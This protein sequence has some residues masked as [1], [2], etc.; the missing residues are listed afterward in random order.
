MTGDRAGELLAEL[1]EGDQP[2]S[3]AAVDALL[4][5]ARYRRELVILSNVLSETEWN[6]LDARC[7]ALT[8]DEWL[9]LEGLAAKEWRAA[10]N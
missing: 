3:D 9:V 1:R 4:V 7:A 2:L 8:D 6:D 10:A 5:M